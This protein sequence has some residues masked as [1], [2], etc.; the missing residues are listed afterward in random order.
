MQVETSFLISFASLTPSF[1][2]ELW[3]FFAFKSKTTVVIII[4]Y[5]SKDFP[6]N[7]IDFLRL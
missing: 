2:C 5:L 4:A 3:D 1:L 6:N 7:F